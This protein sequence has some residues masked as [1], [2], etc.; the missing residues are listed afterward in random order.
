MDPESADALT[1]AFLEF[2]ADKEARVAVLYGE[3]GAFCAVWDLK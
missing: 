3:S 1:Q 2:D